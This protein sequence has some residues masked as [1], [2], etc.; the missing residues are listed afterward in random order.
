MRRYLLMANEENKLVRIDRVRSSVA[1]VQK[2]PILK[3]TILRQIDKGKGRIFDFYLNTSVEAME[4]GNKEGEKLMASAI[5]AS[6]TVSQV[7][8]LQGLSISGKEIKKQ[9]YQ[10]GATSVTGPQEVNVNKVARS[11]SFKVGA[12]ST[13]YDTGYDVTKTSGV[14]K[15]SPN[16]RRR[17]YI[18]KRQEQ[19]G[20]SSNILHEL[21]TVTTIQ[22][23]DKEKGV[24]LETTKTKKQSKLKLYVNKSVLKEFPMMAKAVANQ[25]NFCRKTVT[26]IRVADKEKGVVLETTKTKKQSKLKLYVNKS[27]LKEFP[28]MAKAVANQALK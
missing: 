28:M 13:E 26:T 17:P 14:V 19:K 15:K 12:N 25:T 11:D 22:V 1:D 4:C 9:V 5:K 10:S 21:K 23:A 2:D 24:V 18:K 3:K 8:Q 6:R 16:P 7:H 27:V 20:S